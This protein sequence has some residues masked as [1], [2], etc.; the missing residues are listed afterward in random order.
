MCLIPDAV[1]TVVCASDDVWRYH[2]KRVEQF[3]DIHKLYKV[4][5]C[6]IYI[7][8]CVL[9]FRPLYKVLRLSEVEKFGRNVKNIALFLNLEKK[10]NNLVI[11]TI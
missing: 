10:F 3:P 8:V 9:Q 6:W 4:A 5:S 2:P 7:G 1:D 11:I